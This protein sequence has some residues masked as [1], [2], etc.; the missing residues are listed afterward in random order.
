MACDDACDGS[1]SLPWSGVMIFCDANCDTTRSTGS[2]RYAA[3][4]CHP[5][6]GAPSTNG[7]SHE[8]PLPSFLA[9]MDVG[10]PEDRSIQSDVGVEFIGV[11]S[12]VERCRGRGLKASGG[13]RETHAGKSP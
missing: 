9:A 13:R 8:N 3:V 11:R 7:H 5:S 1:T 6:G 10:P 2:A 4:S 12:G